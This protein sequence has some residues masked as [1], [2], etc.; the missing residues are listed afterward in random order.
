[1]LDIL[2]NIYHDEL[3]S[4]GVLCSLENPRTPE[5]NKIRTQLRA[6]DE[7]IAEALIP[8][9]ETLADK[10]AEQSFYTGVRFGAQLMAQLLEEF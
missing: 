6:V 3:I 4:L 9:I 5:E 7:Q 10:Q 8:S 2:T 1:M